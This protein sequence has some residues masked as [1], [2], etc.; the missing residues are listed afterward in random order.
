MELLRQGVDGRARFELFS[1]TEYLGALRLSQEPADGVELVAA[2]VLSTVSITVQN[3]LPRFVRSGSESVPIQLRVETDYQTERA[4]AQFSVVVQGLAAPLVRQLSIPKDENSALVDFDVQLGALRQATLLFAADG[5]PA[6]VAVVSDDQ[7]AVT[8]VPTSLTLSSSPSIVN[9]LDPRDGETVAIA[10]QVV[11]LD[12]EGDGFFGLGG[13][14]IFRATATEVAHG[15]VSHI[16]VTVG[17]VAE[18]AAGIYES[19]LTLRLAAEQVSA[20]RLTIAVAGVGGAD[21]RP[22]ATVEIALARRRAV[23]ELSLSLSAVILEQAVP[24]DPLQTTATVVARD[25]FGEPIAVDGLRLSVVDTADETEVLRTDALMFDARG[26]ARLLLNL[27]SLRDRDRRLRVALTGVA[28]PGVSSNAVTLELITVEA[29]GGLRITGPALM[30]VQ[31]APNQAVRFDV[32]VVAEGSRGSV[33]QPTEALR[34]RHAAAAGVVVD[35][36]PM[37][38]FDAAGVATVTVTVTPLPGTDAMVTFDAT[39]D[40]DDLAGVMLSPDVVTVG[41][42]EALGTVRITVLGQPLQRTVQSGQEAVTITVLLSADYVGENRPEQT[43]LQLRAVGSNGA[44]ASAPVEVLI[45]AGSSGAAKLSFM[46]GDARQSTVSFEIVNLPEGAVIDSPVISVDLVAVP[47]SLAV[48][49]VPPMLALAP[50]DAVVA[51]LRIRVLVQGSDNRP[52]RGFKDLTLVAAAS[53]IIDGDNADLD[54]SADFAVSVGPISETALGFYESTLTVRVAAGK[55]SAASVAVRASDRRFSGSL[56]PVFTH[57]QLFRPVILDSLEITLTED[58]LVQP[59]IGDVLQT[60]ATVVARDQF[61]R[62]FMPTDLQLRVVDTADETEVLAA[63][64]QFDAAGSARLDLLPAPSPGRN[65]T[66]RVEVGGVTDPEVER[67]TVILRLFRVEVLG[68]VAVVGPASTLTQTMAGEAVR[69]TVTVTGVGTRGSRTWPLRAPLLLQYTAAPE[70]VRVAYDPV[71]DFRIGAGVAMV[72]VAVTPPRGTDAQLVFVVTGDPQDFV[73]VDVSPFAVTVG[74]VEALSTVAVTVVGGLQRMVASGRDPILITV[75][76]R[77]AYFGQNEPAQTALQLRTVSHNGGGQTAPVDVVVPADSSGTAEFTLMLGSAVESTVGF[78]VVGL[79]AGV[80]L[81]SPILTLSLL[82]GARSITDAGMLR[83]YCTAL[84]LSTRLCDRLSELIFVVVGSGEPVW[85]TSG[86][87]VVS[88]AVAAGHYSCMS[89][90][91]DPPTAADSTLFF[92]WSLGRGG[93]SGTSQLNLW[94]NPPAGHV[95]VATADNADF[96][97]RSENGFSARTGHSVPNIE[98]P[99][100]VLKWCYFGAN[101]NPG[102]QDRAQLESLR[103]NVSSTTDNRTVIARYCTALDVPGA[104]CRRIDRIEFAGPFRL[105]NMAWDSGHVVGAPNGGGGRSVLSPM[106]SSSEY[107]CL[108]LYFDPSIPAGQQVGFA[109]DVSREPGSGLARLRAWRFAPGGGD[110]H[111]PTKGGSDLSN[112]YEVLGDGTASGFQGWREFSH[113]ILPAA[114]GE[115]KWC[116]FGAN[117]TAG[118]RDQGRIDRLLLRSDLETFADTETLAEYCTALNMSPRLCDRLSGVVFARSGPGG[119]VWDDRHAAG[120]GGGTRSVASPVVAADGYSCMSL[121]FSPPIAASSDIFFDWSAGRSGDSGTAELR[122]WVAP[123]PAHVPMAM[124]DTGDFIRQSETGLGAWTGHSV[125]N[126]ERPIP[127]LKWCYFGASASPEVRDIGRI[128]RLRLNVSRSTD[129]RTVI[130]RYCASLNI[131]GPS[132]RRIDRIEFAGPF[133]LENV[134]WDSEHAVGIP[135]GGGDRSV[136]SPMISSSEYSCFSVYFDPPVPA[137]WDLRFVWDVSREP[138]F[139]L[140]RIRTWRFAPGGGDDHIPMKGG[141]G[142]RDDYGVY[143]GGTLSDFQGW[144]GFAHETLPEATG[145][146][147]WCYFSASFRAGPRDHSRVDRLALT[148]KRDTLSEP[149]LLAE[150]CT[151]LNMSDRLCDRLSGIGFVRGGPVGEDV[152]DERHA[153]GP[154]GETRS[155]LSPAVGANGYACMSLYFTPP[156]PPNSDL[157]FDWSAGRDGDSGTAQLQLWVAPPPDHVP[158]ATTDAA[159]FIQRSANGFGDWMEHSVRNIDRPI[160]EL[161]WCYFGTSASPN[162]EDNHGRIDRLHLNATVS[163]DDRTA[164]DRYCAALSVPGAHC[165]YIST[166]AFASPF[167]LENA[168]WD[169]EYGFGV[170]G[171]GDRSVLSPMISDREYSC[172]SVYFDPPVPAGWDLVFSW[173]ASREPGSGLARLR[174]WRFAPGGGDGHI[175]QKGGINVADAYTVAGDGLLSD[176]QG[177]REGA[178]VALPAD[179]GELKWCYFGAN[180]TAGPLDH[181][182]VDRLILRTDRETLNEP[183]VLAEYCTALNMSEDFCGRL[184]SIVFVKNRSGG[185]HWDDRHAVGS[186]GGDDRSV[187]SPVV[188]A[189]DYSC[190]SL[191]FNPPL[192]VNADISFSWSAGRSVGGGTARLQLWAPPPLDHVPAANTNGHFIERSENG[193][194]P[195][196]QYSARLGSAAGELKWCYFGVKGS[197]TSLDIGRIDRLSFMSFPI[198]SFSLSLSKTTLVQVRSLEPVQTVVTVVVRDRLN[199]PIAPEGLR[200]R[201]VDTADESEVRVTEP[202]RF[203]NQGRVQQSLSLLPPRGRDQTLRVELLGVSAEANGNTGTLQ[204][205]AVEVLGLLTITGPPPQIQ[206]AAGEELRFV[207]TVTAVGS[208]GSGSWQPSERLQL[209]HT[210]G[211]GATVRYDPML[212]FVDG[213][214]TVMVA[215]T[216]SPGNNALLRFAVTGN[217]LYLADVTINRFDVSVSAVPVLNRVTLT[218]P[219]GRMRTVASGQESVAIAVELRAEYL[220]LNVPGQTNLQLSASGSNGVGPVGSVMVAVPANGSAGANFSLMLGDA[221]QS[222]VSFEVVGLPTN[223]VL[224][225]PVLSVRLVPVPASVVISASPQAILDLDPHADATAEFRLI[226]RVQG[227]DDRPF[228]GLTDL[229]LRAAGTAV[230][231]G[232]AGDLAFLSAVLKESAAG[233]YESTLRVTVNMQVTAASVE[234]GVDGV[235]GRDDSAGA[236]TVVELM[237]PRVLSGVELEL[238]ETVLEQQVPGE[239]V[240]T[241]ATVRV[242]DQFGAAFAAPELRLRVVDA[243]D[244]SEVLVTTQSPVFDAQGEAQLP[245][246]LTPP[247]GRDQNLR[248]QVVGVTDPELIPSA[249][250]VRLIAVEVLGVLTITGPTSPPIQTAPG[251]AVIFAIGITG[252]G[253]KGTDSWQQRLSEPLRLQHTAPPGVTVAYE[254]ILTFNGARSTVTVTV[255]PLPGTNAELRFSVTGN[256][257]DLIGVEANE[258]VV[259]VIPQQVLSKVTLTVPGERMRTVQ[260]GQEPIAITVQVM[261]EY[262]GQNVPAQTQLQLRAVGSNGVIPSAPVATVVPTDGRGTASLS[263]MLGDARQSTVSFEVVGLPTN[264]VLE[265]PVLSVKLVPVPASLMISVSPQ[266]IR[267][268]NS[269]G[270]AVGEFRVEVGVRGSDGR[271]FGG[272]SGLSLRSTVTEV[273]HGDDS[274]VDVSAGRFS[275]IA[276][277]RHE[278][279][280]SVSLSAERVSAATVEI[281]VVAAGGRLAGVSTTVQVARLP[282]LDDLSLQLSATV[283]EQPALG[284]S[285]RVTAT[286]VVRDQFGRPFIPSDLRLRVVDTADDA[287]VRVTEPLL[288]DAQG[289][290][291]SLLVLTPPRGRDQNLRVELSGVT[292]AEVSTNAVAVRLIAVEVLDSLTLSGPSSMPAQMAP[293]EAVVFAVRVSGVGSKGTDSWQLREALQLQHTVSSGALVDYES[294]LTFRAGVATV[295]V[296]VTPLPGTDALVT[297]SVAGDP[298]D[299]AGVAP[300]P[301]AVTIAAIEVLST[302][303]LTVSGERMRTV[304]S[305]QQPVAIAVQL[306]VEYLGENVPEQTALQLRV[307]GTNGLEALAPIAVSVPADGPVVANFN[308]MLG[309]VRQTTVSF[310]VVDLPSYTRFDSPLLSVRLVPVPVSVVI[311]ASPQAILDLE[312][313]AE[314]TAEFRLM[315]SVQGS[316]DQPFGGLTDLMLRTSVTVVAGGEAAD[317]VFSS[318]PLK[319]S[320]AGVYESTLRVTVGMQ[321]TDA[322]VEIGVD[323]VVGRDDPADAVT[324]VE[325]MRPRILHSLELRLA[326]TVLEQQVPGESVQ[327]AA[328]VLAVDQFGAAFEALGLQLRVVAVADGSEVLLTTPALVFDAGG[329]AQALLVL[330]PPRGQDQNLRVEVIGA[331]DPEVISNPVAVQLI[332]VEVLGALTVTGPASTQTQTMPAE[333]VVFDITVTAVGSKGTDSWQQR[334]SEPLQLQ[335]TTAPGVTVVYDPIL[336]FSGARSTVTV[337]VTPLPGTNAE[338]R[339]S[340][341]GN[342][343]DLIGVEANEAVVSVISA[344]SLSTVTLTVPGELMRTVESGQQSIDI[345]VQLM[346]EY[347]GGAEP[348]ETLLQ[349]R[350][351]GSNGVGAVEPVTVAVPA[352]GLGT[353]SFSLML[354]DARQTTVSFEIVGLPAGAVLE[355]PV[356]SVRLVPVPA[357]LMISVSPQTIGNL[358][359]RAEVLAEFRLTVTVQGSDGQPIGGFTDFNLG[360]TVTEVV[361]GDEDAVDVSYGML[362]ETAAGVYESTLR[363][364]FVAEQVSA[365]SVEVAVVDV[366]ASGLVDASASV[367]LARALVLDRLELKLM[368]AVLLQAE[369]GEAVQTTAEVLARDQFGQPFMPTGLRLSVVDAADGLAVLV[370]DALLFDA[371]GMAQSVLSLTPPPGR[372]QNLRVELSGVTDPEVSSNTAT[373]ELIA[374]EILE[375][376]TVF[377]PSSQQQTRPAQPVSFDLLVTAVGSKGTPSW[378]P[379][380]SL[381]LQHTVSPAGTVDYDPMLMFSDGMTT[382]TVTVTPLPG[383]DALVTFR[384]TGDSDDLAGVDPSPLAVTI[385]AVEVLSTVTLT[386]SG[387][388]VRTVESGQDPLVITVQLMAEYLGENVPEQTTLQLRAQGSNGVEASA[389]VKIAVPADSFVATE[390]S[391]MLGAARQSTVSFEVVELPAYTHFDS[392]LLSVEL[393]PVPVTVVISASP[394]AVLDLEPRAEATAEFRLMV[395]IQ[396]SDDQP[397]GGLTDLMLRTTVTAVAGGEAADL[398]FLSAALKESAAGVYEST[399]RVTVGM[400]ITAAS[401]EIGVDG[402]VGRDDPTGAATVVELVRPRILHSLELRLSATVLEQ[403]VPGESLQTTATVVA[404]D[405]FGAPFTATGLQLSVVAAADGSEVLLTTPALV[406][407][408]GGEAR[409]LLV[410]TPP[411]GQDQELQVQV[412]G[413]TDPEVIA[414]SVAVRLTAVEVLS[415]L[416]VAGPASAQTQ[417][418]PAEAVVFAISVTAVGSKGTLWNPME[419]LELRHMAVPGAMVDYDR[420]LIFRGG[421]ATVTVTVT[422]LPGTDALLTF[423]VVGGDSA[424]LAGV[425]T[426][427]VTVSVVA[428]EVLGRVVLTVLDGAEQFILTKMFSIVTELSL[429]A[430]GNRPLSAET[431]LTVLIRASVGSGGQLDGPAVFAVPISGV[432]PS[433]V[434]ITGSLFAGSFDTTVSLSIDDGVPAGVPTVIL[435]TATVT[436]IARANL[437]VDGS[438]QI[439]VADGVLIMQ[440]LFDSLAE[441]TRSALVL[442]LEDLLHPKHPDRRRLDLNNNGAI[443]GDDARILLRYL[444]GLRNSSLGTFNAEAEQR[445]KAIIEAGQ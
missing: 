372:D 296:T 300:S 441:D 420:A 70:G 279:R 229:M 105:E 213:V 124:T 34:L 41:A 331:T 75:H 332:A 53:E 424:A 207:M 301:L 33:W 179:T 40:S 254:P 29:L 418:M 65:Q 335:H 414:N 145:E 381:Q 351:L 287:E 236:V 140:A 6:G 23:A 241:V 92:D 247:R 50:R 320:A 225:S 376:L 94:V 345:A 435:P 89:L 410:L 436:V 35:Y 359:P 223:V 103:L 348:E 137:G 205:I 42:A 231:G 61:G 243:A 8:L 380:E 118:F 316:D 12:L 38:I 368:D 423:S 321:I 284:D 365:A 307:V 108:S 283:L 3:R 288:F 51:E 399:L 18:T 176:F 48:S 122:L 214:A 1:A 180:A 208:K 330:T 170:T 445:L 17:P 429:E 308:L 306:M 46:L 55:V 5:L 364:T 87:A 129:D 292:D 421:V 146:L 276:P 187:A 354:G 116:Y 374:V 167:R 190:M 259:S 373:L 163:T 336:T 408:A 31:T 153:A 318:A 251:E 172:L 269:R 37:L 255:T 201:V 86:A 240:Q 431:T 178:F 234:I 173:D 52:F 100:S 275:E 83:G 342:A 209:Q 184:F 416:V 326:E 419:S 132:C 88:P 121:R 272:L 377:G 428:A 85:G 72:E 66:L 324:V 341:T 220:G 430:T 138:G 294:L 111:I 295:T 215:V 317:L 186:V 30:P 334:L 417:T 353:A 155:V 227:S 392:P 367:Q 384:V 438:G 219:G 263:L 432:T 193:F 82:P 45:P 362:A 171:G 101:A 385:A 439:D 388:L 249:I 79:P 349:L 78:E 360:T 114:V 258:A 169:S 394:Q 285:V 426:N 390:L 434:E 347:L 238:S 126:I 237:R 156:L 256:A 206:T 411:R 281:A 289:K 221:R 305:G 203:D 69:F 112:D 274:H 165:R 90:Y 107:S 44:G 277:G 355:S 211:A 196:T 218:V 131:W 96:I 378:R 141:G 370:T 230:A 311:S 177:W 74:A 338:L 182:R 148:S 309:A 150:Y 4:D 175:P 199:R 142:L 14:L 357:S 315:V 216:P 398:A 39:S 400:E 134:A 273:V 73:G 19:V 346:A 271:P 104:Q 26:Q 127:E 198:A 444:A 286:V 119:H 379:G 154:E 159:D 303:T 128:D 361:H 99:I 262:L 314:A 57:I 280:L 333:A 195:W 188:A 162:A 358:Q 194:G 343:D 356:L 63:D 158:M 339:F 49:V 93:G 413:V 427:R 268:L 433:R 95:P 291:Q 293:A 222:T 437:D 409:A 36:E 123:P 270:A 181:G 189:G 352:G 329:E 10:V 7:V 366:G 174:A 239:S 395:S 325:L 340:V 59:N 197:P 391:L 350:V 248:V 226:V 67:N 252:V 77:T 113:G 422:P 224:E 265:S 185:Q 102:A 401:V 157:F 168:A 80:I 47:V 337:T 212:E 110:D 20:A 210:G 443:D 115:L 136:L 407:D 139:G 382:V 109:W 396:G 375:S 166:I 245:L 344:V 242:T 266:A 298:D 260:S 403:R 64:L 133:R 282:V 91:F 261:T 369:A 327:T 425:T 246:V 183:E 387:E 15:N 161:K 383:T 16:A 290:A 297:F 278:S 160:P 71:L 54:M 232:E 106:I 97:R 228:S 117:A 13:D 304:E 204:L 25:V 244:G 56:T 28:D 202:L 27:I 442:R 233:V 415:S 313:R 257:N 267:E 323:G 76:V 406:F 81:D 192:A 84:E 397:F 60:S 217:L 120:A 152:W 310:E 363:V 393:V 143:G 147:K 58:T 21:L 371:P 125:R 253:S 2:A 43:V 312:P 151:A 191:Y 130:D 402:V 149:G 135:N 250:A 405:Q 144:R 319:E 302:V 164:I 322:S 32:T 22:P 328:T 386:V 299:L 440:Y 264:V 68:F 412:V 404:R 200:L 235:V 9:N 62:P 98:R 11:A 24:D 389:L